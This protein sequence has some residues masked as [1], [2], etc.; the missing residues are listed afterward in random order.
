MNLVL[1]WDAS[2]LVVSLAIVNMVYVCVCNGSDNDNVV[3]VF[4]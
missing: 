1:E 4:V 3:E 2:D